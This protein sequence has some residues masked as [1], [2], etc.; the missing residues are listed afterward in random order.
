MLPGQR[1]VKRAVLLA[2]GVPADMT[3]I[4]TDITGNQNEVAEG[5]ATRHPALAALT[6]GAIGVVFGG[7][8]TSPL[9]A[10]REALSQS[11][12]DGIDPSEILGVL[13]L[14]LWTLFLVVTVKYV[15]FLMRADN[16]GEGGVL[17]TW[18]AYGG[19]VEHDLRRGD[20]VVFCS[21][22]RHNVTRIE[23]GTR[24]S[25][26]VELWEHGRNVVNRHS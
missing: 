5:H 21:E 19:R 6:V 8:G 14:A 20:A 22:K 2:Q 7:I 15:I 13:S 23:S 17:V 18:D 16:Q 26:V 11:A 3:A 1:G 4:T 12:A 9:Y 24:R 10:F 25:A